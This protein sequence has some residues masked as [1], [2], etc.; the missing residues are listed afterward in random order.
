VLRV[1][2]VMADVTTER[3]EP[4]TVGDVR[5][6]SVPDG[7]ERQA[8]R[9]IPGSGFLLTREDAVTLG[10]GGTSVAVS[11]ETKAG[12]FETMA[13]QSRQRIRRLVSALRLATGTTAR[14]MVDIAG[15]RDVSAHGR[16]STHCP[17]EGGGSPTARR[18][19]GREM[20][21]GSSRSCPCCPTA[22]P[23]RCRVQ[24]SLWVDSSS[25]RR[26]WAIP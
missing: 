9:E 7:G 19:S 20:R 17:T 25:A 22:P 14:P 4:V 12:D 21:L 23:L 3:D 8:E 13:T 24:S 16:R 18:C 2:N 15:N 11:D 10:G 6:L 1:V 26:T 5:V